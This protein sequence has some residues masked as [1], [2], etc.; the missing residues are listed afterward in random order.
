[1]LITL[2]LE[3]FIVQHRAN[4]VDETHTSNY[5]LLGQRMIH[6]LIRTSLICT[7]TE[8]VE[9]VELVIPVELPE[10]DFVGWLAALAEIY[11]SMQ[12]ICEFVIRGVFFKEYT[13][14]VLLDVFYM[15]LMLDRVHQI[16]MAGVYKHDAD[17]FAFL[18][19]H[20]ERLS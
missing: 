10:V 4:V 1:M 20:L 13:N 14:H 7:P 12:A 15:H 18:M 8:L 9:R 17:Y 16:A 6:W 3:T 5:H 11:E 2:L 19:S